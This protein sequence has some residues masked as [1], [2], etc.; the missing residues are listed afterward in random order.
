MAVASVLGGSA[1]QGHS[2]EKPPQAAGT[3]G[4]WV[5]PPQNW[6]PIGGILA[7]LRRRYL[8]LQLWRGR[9]M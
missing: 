2:H 1:R 5:T 9:Y 4:P 3:E 7:G 8:W 6:G